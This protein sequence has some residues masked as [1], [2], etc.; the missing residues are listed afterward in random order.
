MCI[1]R[2]CV[3]N[4]LIAILIAIPIIAMWR[5][6]SLRIT[7]DVSCIYSI[8]LILLLLKN[9]F[10]VHNN[11]I[12]VRVYLGITDSFVTEL[13]HVQYFIIIIN[14]YTCDSLKKNVCQ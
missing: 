12:I 3:Q 11:I 6:L 2:V 5:V 7:A 1:I 8:A 9:T 14:M 13:N 4:E 10:S